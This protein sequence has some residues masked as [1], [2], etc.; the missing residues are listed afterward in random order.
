MSEHTP[1]ATCN[2]G[3]QDAPFIA[4]L[5]EA[6]RYFEG[7]PTHGEDAA[8]WAN[9]SNAETCRKIA[10]LLSSLSLHKQEARA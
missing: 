9:V 5:D 10:A 3:L 4:F 1:P 6:A 8:H 7:R 2:E